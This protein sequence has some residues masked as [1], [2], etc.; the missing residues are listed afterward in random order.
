MKKRIA[1][2][3]GLLAALWI[4]GAVCAHA[5]SVTAQVSGQITDSSGAVVPQA[6][7]TITNVDTGL[8]RKAATSGAGYYLIPLLPPGRYKLTVEKPG[9]QLAER[10]DLVLQVNQTLALDVVLSVGSVTQV[11][12]IKAEAPL[13]QA[14]SANLGAVISS[15]AVV[16]L[17]LNGR[18]FTQLLTLTPGATPV[19]TAQS[20]NIGGDMLANSGIPGSGFSQPSVNGQWNRTNM[21]LVDGVN[22]T[23]WFGSTYAILPVVDGIQEFK[24]QSHNDAAEYGGV[25]G[26]TVN[27]VTKSGTNSLHGSAWEFVRN[28]VF[29]A[30]NPFTEATRTSPFPYRQNEFGFTVGAPIVIPKA[31]NGKNK[32]WFFF[33]YEGWRYRKPAQTFY[34]FPTATELSGDFSKDF[35]TQTLFDPAT[36][37]SDP[38]NPGGFIRDP[39]VC[40]ASG[41]AVAQGT[42]GAT[43]CNKI[44]AARLDPMAVGFFQALYDPPNLTGVPGYNYYSTGGAFN[45]D[46]TYIG[47]IDQR[48]SD[49]DTAWFRYSRMYPVLG[50][51]YDSK[52][53][54]TYHE[55]PINL[56]GGETHIFRSNLLLDL[57]LGY[58]RRN[59]LYL[60]GPDAWAT[61]GPSLGFQ[62]VDRFGAVDLRLSSPWNSLGASGPSN[63][64]ERNYHFSSILQWVHGNHNITAGYQLYWERYNVRATKPA[65]G[66]RDQYQFANTQTADPTHL[67]TTGDSLASAVL[68]VPAAVDFRHQDFEFNFPSWAPFIEDKWQVTPRLTVTLGLRYDRTSTPH[69]T[70][71]TTSELDYGTGNW[72][73]GGGKM[74]P[75]CNVANAAPC[76]PGDGNLAN[77]SY[78]DKIRLAANPDLGPYPVSTNFGPRISIAWRPQEKTVVRAGYGLVYDSLVGMI[79]V[80]QGNEGAWPDKT[81]LQYSMN[82][83]GTTL[84]TLKGLQQ[85]TASILPI[86]NPWASIAW[87]F[88]PN[89]K[90]ARSQQWNL[91]IQRE[92]TNSLMLSIGYVGSNSDRLSAG[93]LWNLSPVAGPGTAAEVRARR[94][95]P[96]AGT[97][98]M[99]DSRGSS[100][101]HA[102]A[103]QAEKRYSKGLQFLV[104]YTWSKTMENGGS[105]LFGSNEGGAGGASQVQNY[106]D[107]SRNWGV[108]AYD[109]TNYLSAAIQ[110]AFPA[111]RG[112]QFLNKGPLSYILGDWQANTI[113]QLRSGQPYNLVAP[114]D[115]ANLGNDWAAYTYC[116]PNQ[117][118]DWHVANPSAAQYFNQAAFA[119]PVY[120]FGNVGQNSMRSAPVYNVDFS[121][122]KGI[123][124]KE[125]LQLEFRAEAYNIFNIQNLNVPG[126]SM[127]SP[128][129]FGKVSSTVLPPRQIQLGMKL[130][131]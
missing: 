6:S 93:G 66:G 10:P 17:P 68:G 25:L 117:V 105:G 104:S 27:I 45:N 98:G 24:V 71:G 18:N 51:A 28:N 26:G 121:L 61:I 20:R 73:I 107:L 83:T 81:A 41:T 33:T 82:A 131:F 109:I 106:N 54:G 15:R 92:M 116:R 44:P 49:H 129:S 102:L 122:F 75:A 87:N 8:T 126:V 112:K 119:I 30:R 55:T 118:S 13:L 14:T 114:G 46:N 22:D 86:A 12:E 94:P 70:S 7:I 125:N 88:N 123:R 91:G 85:V 65:A 127:A 63:D 11:V 9:F 69:L 124:L 19:S 37:R 47:K 58:A 95:F 57:R 42:A 84:T 79:Q 100:N 60:S 128:S 39:F 53:N 80:Y 23:A 115:P 3:L 76:I 96:W 64:D 52:W 74:P 43:P 110:Y 4:M 101:Y 36:T 48:F 113:T 78:G 29:D 97:T 32:T 1:C 56:A 90:N 99:M 50:T 40:D 120:S 21:F 2:F 111:G 59:T 89:M 34:R 31:Y 16:D 38:N 72:I 103:I 67:G 62:G 130:V 35:S 77:I 5:Q 108:A